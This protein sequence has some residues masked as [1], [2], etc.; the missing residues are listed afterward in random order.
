M[1]ADVPNS[2]LPGDL[3]FAAASHLPVQEQGQTLEIP[4]GRRLLLV[5]M[6]PFTAVMINTLHPGY[7]PQEVKLSTWG[8][9]KE[10]L[11]KKAHCN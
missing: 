7:S 8:G 1:S 4:G 2:S 11:G 10:T 3:S 6:A 5:I 9:A